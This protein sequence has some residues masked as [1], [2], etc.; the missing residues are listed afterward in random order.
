MNLVT[1]F[2]YAMVLKLEDPISYGALG[3]VKQ[4]CCVSVEM[5]FIF[6]GK[7]GKDAGHEATISR[8][9]KNLYKLFQNKEMNSENLQAIFLKQHDLTPI[10]YQG[11]L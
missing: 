6:V 2:H 11:Q 5:I 8:Q 7:K 4:K 10:N 3:P 9:S 1:C